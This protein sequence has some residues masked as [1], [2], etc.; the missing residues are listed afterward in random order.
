MSRLQNVWLNRVDVSLKGTKVTV[1][2]MYLLSEAIPKHV[3]SCASG[4]V[5]G[6]FLEE[7]G[8]VLFHDLLV[9]PLPKADLPPHRLLACRRNTWI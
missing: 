1:H 7:L 2:S 4:E 3:H 5:F 8:R 6:E 9:C